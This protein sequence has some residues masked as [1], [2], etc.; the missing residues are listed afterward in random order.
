MIM[1][2]ANLKNCNSSFAILF[3]SSPDGKPMV[4]QNQNYFIVQPLLPIP[5]TFMGDRVTN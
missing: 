1:N 2:Q 5:K 3:I 4:S